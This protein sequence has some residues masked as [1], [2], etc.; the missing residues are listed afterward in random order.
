MRAT[1]EAGDRQKLVSKRV[2]GDIVGV[3]ADTIRRA[4]RAGTLPVVVVH[5]RELIPVD[6]LDAYLPR[7]IETRNDEVSA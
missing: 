5:K 1:V 4:V 7:S 3:S 6:A 2:A